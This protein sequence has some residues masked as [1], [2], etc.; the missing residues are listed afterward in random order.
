MRTLNDVSI[1]GIVLGIFII[2]WGIVWLGNDMGLWNLDFP[3]WPVII[4]LAGVV[5]IL[6][7]IKKTIKK[8]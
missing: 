6:H 3:F 5:I 8:N 4:I 1:G 2:S 7:E